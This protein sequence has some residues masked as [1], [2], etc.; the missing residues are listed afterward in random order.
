MQTPKLHGALEALRAEHKE[1]SLKLQDSSLYDAPEK[2]A[3]ISRRHRKL[4]DFLRS[5]DEYAIALK[6]LTEAEEM[7]RSDDADMA[8]MAEGEI[9]PLKEK[10]TQLEGIIEDFLL[11]HNPDESKNI[12]LEIRAGT[13]GDEAE[14][15]AGEIFRMYSRYA[16]RQ[17]W[18]VEITTLNRSE[19]GGMKEVVAGIIGEDVYR[20][21]Q[22]ESGVHRVQRVPETEKIGRIHTSAATVAILPEAEEADVE[23]H[24]GDLQIDTY[25][26]G[27]AGGQHVNTTDSAVRI[28]HKPTGLVVTSQDERSQTKNKAR[29]M[30]VLRARLYELKRQQLASERAQ[31]RLSQIGSGDRSEKIRTYNFPQDRITDHRIGESWSNLPHIMEGYI[32]DIVASLLR[33]HKDE[34]REQASANAAA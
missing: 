10:I 31:T 19:L 33:A 16:E 8:A 20:H 21:L 32:D 22:F 7:L 1:L 30:T 12:I 23:V 15:F 13:G 29:A 24:D 4:E 28:T 5:A 2:A 14:L 25:R 34:L 9:E 3:E 18:K 11:P 26:S 17:G 6:Q 27:G